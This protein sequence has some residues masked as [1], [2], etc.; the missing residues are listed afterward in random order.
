M[1]KKKVSREETQQTQQNP[2]FKYKDKVLVIS[3]FFNGQKAE[4][5]DMKSHG[6]Y[7]VWILDEDDNICRLATIKGERLVRRAF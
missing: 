6:R 4:I 5:E 2:E 7:L 1:F 3:G